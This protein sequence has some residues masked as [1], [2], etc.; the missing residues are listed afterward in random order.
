MQSQNLVV[1][2]LFLALVLHFLVWFFCLV[3]DDQSIQW[4][5]Q[6]LWQLNGVF[7]WLKICRSLMFDVCLVFDD[8]DN[9]CQLVG[10]WGEKW[11]AE[12]MLTQALTLTLH[13]KCPNKHILCPWTSWKSGHFVRAS[14]YCCY[15]RWIFFFCWEPG[16]QNYILDILEIW[17][18]GT[19][20]HFLLVALNYIFWEPCWQ[21][22]LPNQQKPSFLFFGR[23]AQCT[24]TPSGNSATGLNLF[25]SSTNSH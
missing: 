2:R 6:T 8:E 20:R 18:F 12:Q 15:L 17:N 16:W 25:F 24:S 9:G 7:F 4:Q 5:W 21:K 13:L 11:E 23:S 19:D 3:F 14:N 10:G 22:T 1:Q